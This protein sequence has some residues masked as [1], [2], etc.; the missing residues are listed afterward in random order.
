[1]T[2][3][4]N[5]SESFTDDNEVSANGA[6]GHQTTESPT[7]EQ[8]EAD[9]AD[10]IDGVLDADE[11]VIEEGAGSQPENE[12][13]AAD[14]ADDDEEKKAEADKALPFHNHPRFREVINDR[15]ELRRIAQEREAPATNWANLES[16]VEGTVGRE[17]FG[18][19]L[20][21]VINYRTDPAQAYQAIR[22]FVRELL[23]ANG[24][25]L[26]PEV[27]NAVNASEMTRERAQELARLKAQAAS[28]E[29]AVR[30]AEE[31]SRQEAQQRAMAEME[32]EGAA[33]INQMRASDPAFDRK[34]EWVA[35]RVLAIQAQEGEP[36]TVTEL[37][38][39]LAR[40]YADVNKAFAP[41]RGTSKPVRPGN[42]SG[43]HHNIVPTTPDGDLD[44][45]SIID[46]ELG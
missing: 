23:L 5:V 25:I 21:A 39:Q 18:G 35:T 28:R 17:M 32:R 38:A 19:I 4:R 10:I 37:K 11:G 42:G 34:S 20:Q 36:G 6:A 7:V 9:F 31:A 27:Q 24:D 12:E 13:D 14:A 29:E 1:M 22:P 40:A 41:A 26:P 33:W 45:L 2:D 44:I 30:R 16:V 8:A 43:T 15:N 46:R 3:E